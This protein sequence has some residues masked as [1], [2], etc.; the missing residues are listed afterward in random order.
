MESPGFTTLKTSSFFI[1]ISFLIA[2]ACGLIAYVLVSRQ[3]TVPSGHEGFQGPTIGVSEIPCGQESSHAMAILQI[4]S[5]KISI[6]E[7]GVPDLKEFKLILSKLC[8]LKHDLMSTAQVVQAMLY[9]PYNTTHDRENPA[10]IAGRCF[11]KSIPMRDLDIT[12][13]TWKDR[14]LVLV[15]RLCTSYNLS[16]SE[17]DEIQNKFTGLWIDVFSIAKNACIVTKEDPVY[18]SPRDPKG[19]TPEDIQDLG[20]YKGYY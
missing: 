9:L 4:F 8:C 2:A 12:F 13:G 3:N 7:E 6:T 14:G 16:S 17:S 19:F 20:S 10:D 5:N 1:A 15:S 11:T 18:E